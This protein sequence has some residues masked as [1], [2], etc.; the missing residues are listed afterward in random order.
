MSLSMQSDR[1]FCIGNISS[2]SGRLDMNISY[3]YDDGEIK[4][5]SPLGL[6]MD[7]KAGSGRAQLETVIY[8]NDT[9]W[10]SC[11]DI[12]SGRTI[13][14]ITVELM[15]S[16]GTIEQLGLKYGTGG[17]D[18][19]S[20]TLMSAWE[21]QYLRYDVI[22]ITVSGKQCEI[23][24]AM[25][26]TEIQLD[27][28]EE[29]TPKKEDISI[30]DEDMLYV[31]NIDKNVLSYYT[32]DDKNKADELLE[33]ALASVQSGQSGEAFSAIREAEKI[34]VSCLDRSMSDTVRYR[35][36]L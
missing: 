18:P 19:A 11:K 4:N 6:V 5:I 33:N 15:S 30:S 14:K 22:E 25:K 26:K 34:I 13:E 21:P 12:R 7:S 23:N 16:E 31:I 32:G 17:I 29:K 9:F 20:K 2:S 8:F 28:A 1:F 36:D 35:N 24:L 27:F 10:I 3:T